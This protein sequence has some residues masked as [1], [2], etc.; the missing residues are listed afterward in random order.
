MPQLADEL[1][2][3]D[4][5]GLK[6]VQAQADEGRD[7][8]EAPGE[9]LAGGGEALLG[10]VVGDEDLE[11]EVGVD[12]QE[13][14]QDGVGGGVERA[15]GEGSDGQG[16]DAGGD[17]ALKAPVIGAVAGIRCG[18]GGS[19]VDTA[20]DD[21]WGELAIAIGHQHGTSNTGHASCM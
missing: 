16:H 3:A 1:G 8:V 13:G 10:D 4:I 19:V 11:A 20:D 17:E 7:S 5:V 12:E 9:S 15:G 6:L 21:L 18:D 14:A 2:D